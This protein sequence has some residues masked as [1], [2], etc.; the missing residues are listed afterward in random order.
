MDEIGVRIGLVVGALA[1]AGVSTLV[2][3]A[4]ARGGP[5][6]LAATGLVQG[7]YLFTSKACLDCKQAR[8]M[9]DDVLGPDGYKELSWEQEPGLFHELGVGGVPAT[10]IVDVDGSGVV[11][12]GR[13]DKALAHRGP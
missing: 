11:W 3:R 6:K 13:P 4:R 12:P 9:L 10:M 1:V 5:R 8:G 7:V 2:L